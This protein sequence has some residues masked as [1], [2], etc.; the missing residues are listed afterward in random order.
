MGSRLRSSNDTRTPG[1]TPL[2]ASAEE[3]PHPTTS[4]KIVQGEKRVFS[5]FA[6]GW[7]VQDVLD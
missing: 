4:P 5:A 2:D 3:M 6:G 7:H 1:G